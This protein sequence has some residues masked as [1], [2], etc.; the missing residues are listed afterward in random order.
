M[1]R[2]QVCRIPAILERS[3]T[4][5]AQFPGDPESQMAFGLVC[6]DSDHGIRTSALCPALNLNA[7]HEP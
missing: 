1:R 7:F 4:C 2:T 6:L 5:A 3:Y